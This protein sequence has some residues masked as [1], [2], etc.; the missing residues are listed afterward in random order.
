MTATVPAASSVDAPPRLARWPRLRRA[1][2]WATLAVLLLVAQLVSLLLTLHYRTSRAQA[3]VDARVQAGATE[4][5]QI[6]QRDM[7]A[8]LAL[9]RGPGPAWRLRAD[10]LLLARPEALL[11]ERRDLALA[12][13][14]SAESRSRP[15]L[16]KRMRRADLEIETELACRA[17]QRR[18]G[19]SFSRSYFVPQDDGAGFEVIDLCIH[20][21]DGEHDR[22]FVTATFSLREVLAEASAQGW[23]H[24]SELSFVEPDGTLL[25]HGGQQPSGDVRQAGVLR[26][27]RPVVL[28]GI[29]LQLRLESGSRRPTLLPDV[30]TA[31]VLGL[32]L[33]LVVVVL[34][35]V[36]DL[37]KRSRVERQ[38]AEA[39]A[40][41]KAM[42]D[43]VVTGLRARD[44][45]GRITYVNPAFCTMTGFGA[46][47][48]VGR[49][50]PPYWPPEQLPEYERRHR[51]RLSAGSPGEAREAFETRF[52]RR[53]GEPFPVMIFESPLVDS[54]GRHTG[55]MSTVLDLSAQRKVEELARQQQ[56]RL[57]ATARLAT[58]GEMASL[59][60]HEL[61]QPLSAIAAYA[62]GSLNLIDDPAHGELSAAEM[63]PLLRHAVHHIAA[64]AERAGRVIRSVH[65]FV[66]R[67]ENT[68][69]A[70]GVD[71]LV[72]AV[73][74]LVR[75]QAHKSGARIEL[76]LCTPMP[77]VV[78]DRA[79]IEQVLLNL[80]RNGIQAMETMPPPHERLLTLRVRQAHPQWVTISVVD[81]GAGVDPAVA[82]QLFTPF[83]TTRREGMGLGLS[84]CRTIVEQ[85]S[86]VLDYE[87]VRGVDGTARGAIFRFSLPA[88]PAG[89]A[90]SESE[91]EILA[92][93]ETEAERPARAAA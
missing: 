32:S 27:S 40:F 86:G 79:M 26:A 82:G 77:R 30:V 39:L 57:Q 18:G 22:G 69:D 59:L 60:S 1:G 35:L 63:R 93:A 85:H 74:P 29:A 90:G 76:D 17:A 16:F 84:V 37:R 9:P 83:F 28:P 49:W 52:V 65:D 41:R 64:Q 71:R 23:A 72:E 43:S 68:R 3:D 34:L 6:F 24:G 12:V 92:D 15:P 50:P 89:G 51:A 42:E 44:L 87:N 36:G 48:L 54:A 78:C 75:L 73:L 47:E 53:G 19:P 4:L 70:V 45:D 33:T 56:E 88:A 66:R 5:E 91:A 10:E 80:T 11:V 62:T 46:D 31:L 20:D 67:R 38:L 13:T 81:A 14:E 8:V 25:A 55:W 2:L 61:N 7:Y 21:R 58:V